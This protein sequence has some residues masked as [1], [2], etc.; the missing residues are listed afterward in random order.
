VY[1]AV[2]PLYKV[3]EAKRGGSTPRITW[4][5][6]EQHVKRVCG[7]GWYGWYE[8]GVF[9]CGLLPPPAHLMHPHAPVLQVTR[10]LP[11][12]SFTLQRFKGLGEM[13][14]EQLWDTTMDPARRRLRRLTIQVR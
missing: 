12:G 1:V 8:W 11:P 6:T 2:P 7:R 3:E 14:P 4:C 10:E 9:A 5:F 13:M